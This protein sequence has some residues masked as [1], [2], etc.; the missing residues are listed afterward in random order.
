MAGVAIG[1]SATHW[2]SD[3]RGYALYQRNG[4]V[5]VFTRDCLV[6]HGNIKGEKTGAFI[7]DELHISIDTEE[8]FVYAELL[9]EKRGDPLET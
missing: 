4:V 9:I 3:K 2:R 6:H 5:Y 8:D 1:G 7:I